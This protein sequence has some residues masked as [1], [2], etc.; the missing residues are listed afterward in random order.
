VS[1]ANDLNHLLGRATD[2]SRQQKISAQR[3]WICGLEH[4]RAGFQVEELED[5]D[6]RVPPGLLQM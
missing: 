4:T 5:G 1:E 3:C 2:L 6:R